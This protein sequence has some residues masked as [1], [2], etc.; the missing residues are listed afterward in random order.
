[1]DVLAPGK[2]ILADGH[3]RYES[4][5]EY[6]KKKMKDN[7]DDTGREAYHYH[8]MYLTNSE[9]DDLK[10]L[11]THRLMTGFDNLGREELLRRIS[12]YFDIKEQEDPY[13][14]NEIISGK[15]WAFGLV[16]KNGTYKLRLKPEALETIDQAFPECVKNLDL[17]VMHYFIIDKVLGIPLQEQRKSQNIH[18]SR[19]FSECLTSVLTDKAHMALITNAV[20]MEEVKSVCYSGYTMPQKSTY[21]Y[22]KAICGFLFGTLVQHEFE[23]S[24]DS[25]FEVAEK[26]ADPSGSR[27]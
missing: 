14:L 20:S 24:V 23:S 4:S 21:F 19:S 1:M 26:A 2:I 11:P 10:I 25:C 8:M 13:G 15:K 7:P 27:V 3:H 16:L 9:S 22:P 5:L 17:T 18:F 6:R 12:V